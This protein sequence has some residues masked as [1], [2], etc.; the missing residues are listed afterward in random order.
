[1]SQ[2]TERTRSSLH[3]PGS[4]RP[5]DPAWVLAVAVIAGLLLLDVLGGGVAYIAAACGIGI[6][7]F[8]VIRLRF[9][10]RHVRHTPDGRD[11]AAIGI[12]YVV[13]VALYRVAFTVVEADM[14][15]FAFFAAGLVAGVAIPVVYTVWMRARPLRS[16]GLDVKNLRRTAGF[17]IMF[18]AVQF[19]IT[20]L[21]YD[22]PKPSDWLPLVG[23]ALMVGTFES[24]FFR[25]FIQERLEAAFG[26]L[27]GVFGAAA[28]YGAYHVG[29]GM[30]PEEC[31]FLFGL[32]VIYALAY[33]TVHNVFVLWPLLTPMGSL[34][35]QLQDG[36]LV[37]RLPWAS[38]MG[39]ADV[40]AVFA[41]VLWRAQ[42]HERHV[43]SLVSAG[44]TLRPT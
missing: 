37:G 4:G 25:G 34:F 32:G 1:M 22:L 3:P 8:V 6:A 11:L 16:L 41:F 33:A 36:N 28:L 27:V 35:A 5:S 13:V 21:G 40:I 17:A 9:G 29:Y 20:F 30:D 15:L 12:T 31:A 10:M 26:P 39:F 7:A 23:M 2:L 19:S 24:I 14:V 44:T 38:L 42:R 43:Q 18:A